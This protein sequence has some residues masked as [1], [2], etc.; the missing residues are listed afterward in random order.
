MEALRADYIG[1]INSAARFGK[2]SNELYMEI[3]K[4]KYVLS[5]VDIF[6]DG[7]ANAQFKLTLDN[8][9]IMMET[10]CLKIRYSGILLKEAVEGYVQVEKV[11]YE[12]IGGI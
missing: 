5:D 8:D 12:M 9:F 11:L 3:S 2:L 7:M 1:M 6:W 4:L 10:L